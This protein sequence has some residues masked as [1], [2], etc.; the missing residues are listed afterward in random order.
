MFIFQG[1][2][3]P[4]YVGR[5]HPYYSHVRIPKDMGIVSET[6]HK[7]VPLLGVPENLTLVDPWDSKSTIMLTVFFPVKAIVLITSWRFQPI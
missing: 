2:L 6:Y 4:L 7:G 5:F 1:V 3:G